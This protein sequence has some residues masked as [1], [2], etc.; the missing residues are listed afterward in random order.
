MVNMVLCMVFVIICVFILMW[1]L[2]I[3]GVFFGY[4]KLVDENNFNWINLYCLD[5]CKDC[6]YFDNC[7]VCR[8]KLLWELDNVIIDSLNFEYVNRRGYV[9]IYLD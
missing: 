9:V 3:I 7:C 5:N 1:N 4:F 6:E 8:V 2:F